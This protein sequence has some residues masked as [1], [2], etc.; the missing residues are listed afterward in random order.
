M[1]FLKTRGL[2]C[3]LAVL[4]LPVCA[5]AAA[6]SRGQ[7]LDA[8]GTALE[9]NACPGM[10][11]LAEDRLAAGEDVRLTLDGTLQAVAQSA[12]KQTLGAEMA[13]AVVVMDGEGRLLAWAESEP[14]ASPPAVPLALRMRASPGRT[15]APVTAL[16]A[17]RNGALWPDET[18][19]DMGPFA[20]Y[21]TDQPLYCWISEEQRYK[22]Q[23][24]TVVEGLANSCDSF[25]Y[26]LG[27]RLGPEELANM[28]KD[29]GLD[30]L[31]GLGIQGET[32]GVLSS[33]SSLF[34]PDLPIDAQ[35]TEIPAQVRGAVILHLRQAADQE[36][37]SATEESLGQCA[38]ALMRMAAENGQ[39]EWLL[40]IRSIVGAQL[41]LSEETVMTRDLIE[42]LYDELNRIKWS[43]N[44]IAEAAM[45]R[46]FTKVTPMAM[47]R[48]WTALAN[49]GHVVN[50]QLLENGASPAQGKDLSGEIGPYLGDI[51]KGLEG[52]SD[53]TGK[54]YKPFYDGLDIEILHNISCIVATNEN[55]DPALGEFTWVVGS[56]PQNQPQ[57]SVVVF[58][59]ENDRIEEAVNIFCKVTDAYFDQKAQ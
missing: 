43:G 7:L 27:S 59:P 49:G 36:G 55:K 9:E 16:A 51:R 6:P 32:R 26:T 28:G 41:S 40:Q 22:H 34:A 57:A 18:I 52:A 1:K 15:F 48:Y 14:D 21:S 4:C 13:G 33:Q 29:L 17:L 3:I 45:S 35:Q 24:Q 2:P 31:S 50:P 42:P 8:R 12:L 38:D 54:A 47:A 19:D 25:F 10:A 56:L 11:A 44:A 5:L 20:L 23:H 53:I 37:I 46:S 30:S 58:I 39:A